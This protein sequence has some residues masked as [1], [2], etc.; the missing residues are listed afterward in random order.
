MN[1]LLSITSVA[2]FLLLASCT[3][4]KQD[5]VSETTKKNIAAMH[6]IFN[7]FNTGDFSKLGDYVDEDCIDHS[8]GGKE[9]IRGLAQMK[10]N[11]E[12]WMQMVANS[13]TTIKVEMA[14]DEY[15]ISW[16]SFAMTMKIDV[17]TKKIGEKFEKSDIEILRFKDGKAVEHWTFIDAR[18]L[19]KVLASSK[20][21]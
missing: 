5:C 15:V 18:D 21:N 20:T 19:N 14:N 11:Y 12:Q 6:G 8:S 10:A 1:K 16:V 3:S 9:D 17:A 7:C 2:I 13:K 4:T